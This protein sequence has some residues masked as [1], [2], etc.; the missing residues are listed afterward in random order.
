MYLFFLWGG[1]IEFRH[2]LSTSS[3]LYI[4]NQDEPILKSMHPL[5]HRQC[6]QDPYS[7][8]PFMSA[9]AQGPATYVLPG[10]MREFWV[11]G[12]HS[13]CALKKHTIIPANKHI[14]IHFL[15]FLFSISKIHRWTPGSPIFCLAEERRSDFLP[16]DGGQRHEHHMAS[17]RWDHSVQQHRISSN[18][19]WSGL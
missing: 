9:P 5:W 11:H 8:N 6:S 7:R 10:N 17:I 14:S 1:R 3:S 2:I 19:C 15:W 12:L 13:M 18:P 4:N 16:L